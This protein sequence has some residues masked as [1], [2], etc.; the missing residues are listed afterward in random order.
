LDAIERVP[1]FF[2]PEVVEYFEHIRLA[3]LNLQ[4][5]NMNQRIVSSIFEVNQKRTSVMDEIT[6]FY[7]KA[8][9]LVPPYIQA[10]Q[11]VGPW[12]TA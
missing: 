8:P 6:G 11:K 7:Q 5:T 12:P 3:I 4:A 2:G 9:V 1:F 10:H